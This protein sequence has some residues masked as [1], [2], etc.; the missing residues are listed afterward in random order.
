M[1]CGN[2]NGTGR[3]NEKC[4]NCGGSGVDD[5]GITCSVCLGSGVEVDYCPVCGGSGEITP[6]PSPTSS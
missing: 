1:Q 6:T 3:V 5:N 2:C 4:G